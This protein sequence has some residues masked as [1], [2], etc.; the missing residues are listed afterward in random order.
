MRNIAIADRKDRVS[1]PTPPA[2]PPRHS[3]L[4]DRLATLPILLL[5][6]ALIVPMLITSAASPTLRVTPEEP[7]P[8]QDVTVRG[9]GFDRRMDGALLSDDD[10]EIAT[11]R[12]DAR[13]SF[14]VRF[15]CRVVRRR[16]PRHHGGR[17]R[18]RRARR[19][20]D[21]GR[22]GLGRR[23][24]TT[25]PTATST[26]E[27]TPTA[28][29][30]PAADPTR[31]PDGDGGRHPDADRHPEADGD[32]GAQAHSDTDRDARDAA[33]PRRSGQRHPHLGRRDRPLAD[34]RR[35]LDLA[36]VAR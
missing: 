31:G 19:A 23:G 10:D 9:I 11:F 4:R 18:G 21:R 34:V 8:G 32:A 26:A 17:R 33:R 22:C 12:T 29:P 7:V 30:T 6:P 15:P 25:A 14:T 2:R 28:D 3:M 13:G 20:R 1:D 5:G 35:R 36:Q 16:R 24:P 27:P